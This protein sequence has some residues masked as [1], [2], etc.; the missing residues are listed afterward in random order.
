[1]RPRITLLF[2]YLFLQNVLY[3]CI[4]LLVGVGIYILVDLFDRV[5]VFVE[6]GL[7]V[8]TVVGYYL[9]R[10]PSMVSMI[11]PAC[12]LLATLVQLALMARARELTALQAGGISFGKIA[13]VLFCCGLFF[14]VAQFIFAE[15]VGVHAE[16]RAQTFWEED[17]R[18]RSSVDAAIFN[19]WFED[20]AYRIYVETLFP[21]K[22]A[23]SAMTIYQMDERGLEILRIFQA[24]G[25]MDARHGSWPLHDVTV[26]DMKQYQTEQWDVFTLPIQ[27]APADFAWYDSQSTPG[28]LPLWELGE[29]IQAQQAAGT[30][31]E[32]LRTSWHLKLS[33]PAAL[34]ALALLA[35]AVI[36]WRDNLYLCV[37]IG[38]G[39]TFILYLMTMLSPTLGAYGILPPPLAAWYPVFVV[40]LIAMGR[41]VWFHWP[42][43]LEKTVHEDDA[44]AEPGA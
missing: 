9:L 11:L 18:K 35:V 10:L 26:Y 41:L 29:V 16:R 42:H 33:S 5:D 24:S 20:G 39:A 40:F 30:N 2:R 7:P 19:L 34:L 37:G 38:L 25:T 4:A 1:M 13:A 6:A 17:V 32:S 43:S 36:T 27:A 28:M 15:A 22:G 44:A 31:V 12:F 3:I 23:A 14:G 8:L 21:N